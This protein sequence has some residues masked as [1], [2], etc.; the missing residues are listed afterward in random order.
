MSHQTSHSESERVG[1]VLVIIL[2]YNAERHI[3][4]VLDRIPVALL[5]SSV[6]HFLVLD[7]ASSDAGVETALQWVASHD[8]KNITV[9]R[10][11]VNQG[12]GGNQKIGYRLALDCSFD[13]A[14]IVHGAG[15]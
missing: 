3:C 5:N 9:L 10:N 11:S 4:G 12:Y 6:V 8:V 2:A 1:R 14:V 15:Q 7:D 13:F